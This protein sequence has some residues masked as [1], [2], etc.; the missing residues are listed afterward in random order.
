MKKPAGRPEK[1]GDAFYLCVLN[2]NKEYSY[3][4]L[5]KQ[6]NVSERTVARWI[7]RG[8]ALMYEREQK[9]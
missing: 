1:Y 5:A 3:T 8:K 7:K 9:Q 2:Q 4:D 6:Y